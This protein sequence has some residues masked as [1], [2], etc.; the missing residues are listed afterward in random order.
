[1]TSRIFA[2]LGTLA[3]PGTAWAHPGH[4]A[5]AVGHDHWLALVILGGLG[6][7]LAGW[8]L[9]RLLRSLTRRGRA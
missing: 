8:G 2:F 3:L 9:A 4:I 1:M 5:E 7:A 6:V